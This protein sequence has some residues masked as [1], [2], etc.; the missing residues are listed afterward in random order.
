MTRTPAGSARRAGRRRAGQVGIGLEDLWHLR[1]LLERADVVHN[2]QQLVLARGVSA[3]PLEVRD[4]AFSDGPA[5]DGGVAVR[6]EPGQGPDDEIPLA[7]VVLSG[8]A[9][10]PPACASPASVDGS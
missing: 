6:L 5:S 3:V 1:L 2:G 9:E 4:Q 8:A 7:V 10:G